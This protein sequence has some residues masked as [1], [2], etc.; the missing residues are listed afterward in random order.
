NY[1]ETVP[2]LRYQ[3][4]FET[5]LRRI[6]LSGHFNLGAVV[7]HYVHLQH[8]TDIAMIFQNPIVYHALF[9]RIVEAL[10]ECISII[11]DITRY[12]S[13]GNK[14]SWNCRNGFNYFI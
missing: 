7:S 10:K 8:A 11:P 13:Q 1:Y 9:T 6:K 4:V 5:V 2:P 14:Y 3:F 12:N